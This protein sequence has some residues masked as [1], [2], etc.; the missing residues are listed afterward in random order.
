MCYIKELRNLNEIGRVEKRGIYKRWVLKNP[1]EGFLI[2]AYMEKINYCIQDLNSEL[3]SISQ[4]SS[5]S[6][7]NIIALTTWV[8]QAVYAIRSAYRK[9]SLQGFTYEHEEALLQ[10]LEFLRAIRSFVVAHPLTTE[11][12]EKYSMDGRLRCIDIR[13]EQPLLELRPEKFFAHLDHSG[14]HPGVKLAS[15]FYLYGYYREANADEAHTV[16]IGCCVADIYRV[17]ELY[18]DKLYAMDKYLKNVRRK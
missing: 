8:S 10:G 9:D 12:H 4:L 15:D 2:D 14:Y 11:D 3:A 6:V 1:K 16:Y 17:A 18:I 5:K 7:V 13:F